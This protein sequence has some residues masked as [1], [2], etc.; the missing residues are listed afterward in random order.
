[1]S[2]IVKL[3][4]SIYLYYLTCMFY[5]IVSTYKRI[6]YVSYQGFSYWLII[7]NNKLF[8][9]FIE[10]LKSDE[11]DKEIR[12]KCPK[13]NEVN[14]GA[15]TSGI[16]TTADTNPEAHQEASTSSNKKQKTKSTQNQTKF[17]DNIN[18]IPLTP[19]QIALEQILWVNKMYA[20]QMAEYWQS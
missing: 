20:V 14:Y 8:S 7:F 19:E 12:D 10:K 4:N 6:C 15:S 1:M 16:N 3:L 9:L 17:N 11:I 5:S 18:R 2:F 13:F